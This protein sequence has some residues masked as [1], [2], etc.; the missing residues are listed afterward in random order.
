MGLR[1]LRQETSILVRRKVTFSIVLEILVS[2]NTL[3][4][5]PDTSE[6]A[7]P[8]L[9]PPRLKRVLSTGCKCSACLEP[10]TWLLEVLIRSEG[11][12][13]HPTKRVLCLSRRRTKES[14]LRMA[15]TTTSGLRSP[16]GIVR[17]ISGGPLQ[18]ESRLFLLPRPV[19]K[20]CWKVSISTYLDR[21]HHLDL[22]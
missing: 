2:T 4:S 15:A 18:A 20:M 3:E 19:K 21:T 5:L 16:L 13:C 12:C 14:P 9:L 8:R 7:K 6:P 10:T 1:S 11:G 22:I 17:P